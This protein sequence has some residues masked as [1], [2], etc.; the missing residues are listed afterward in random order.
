MMGISLVPRQLSA[1]TPLLIS[2]LAMTQQFSVWIF[3]LKHFEI[4]AKSISV[5]KWEKTLIFENA[6]AEKT[7]SNLSLHCGRRAWRRLR[8]GSRHLRLKRHR[9]RRRVVLRGPQ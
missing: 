3:D 4:D 9:V 5:N 8:C 6:F 7:D 1:A 2:T